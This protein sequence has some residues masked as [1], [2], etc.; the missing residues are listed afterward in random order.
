[1]NEVKIYRDGT[2]AKL[3]GFI[4]VSIIILSY[5]NIDTQKLYENWHFVSF[6][7][8][9]MILM[10]AYLADPRPLLVIDE[11]GLK[12][13]FKKAI[14]W[15]NISNIEMTRKNF[16]NKFYTELSVF[17]YNNKNTYNLS[18]KRTTAIPE[19]L[20]IKINRILE[21]AHQDHV[22]ITVNT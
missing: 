12:P 22:Q 16:E 20:A 18:L 21:D 13:K 3:Y 17:D 19:E 6:Y 10:W 2:L 7:T 1:M 14:H 15:S 8:L 4:F 9:I 5:I 11:N